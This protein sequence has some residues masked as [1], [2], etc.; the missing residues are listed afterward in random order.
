MSKKLLTFKAPDLVDPV[1]T[2]F[3]TQMA[4]STFHTFYKFRHLISHD[5]T[6]I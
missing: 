4:L 1:H 3:I 2:Q 6:F 5:T